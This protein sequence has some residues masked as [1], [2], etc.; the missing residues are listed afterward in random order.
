MG[1][2]FDPALHSEYTGKDEALLSEWKKYADACQKHGTPAIVQI[3]HPGRQ[4]LRVAGRRGIFGLTLAPS[5]VPMNIGDGW[6]ESIVAAITWPQP[7]EM[8]R[9]DIERVIRQ[10]VD[11]ARLA[12]D[13]GFAGVE[14]HGAHG[15]LLGR[16]PI[17]WTEDSLLTMI[18][19]RSI[20]ECQG[21]II[22]FEMLRKERN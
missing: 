21:E 4:S 6:L 1:T 7:R 3:C 20:P 17:G 19:P 16:F 10:F 5:A 14:L 18:A 13:A 11:T 12:A 22:Y 2:P 9:A 15:Y 8:A